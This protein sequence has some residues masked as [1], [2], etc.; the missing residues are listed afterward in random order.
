MKKYLITGGAGFIGSHLAEKLS[1]KANV[2][3]IDNLFQ[4]NKLKLNKNIKLVVGD[5][6]DKKLV[7]KH[8]KGCTSIFHLAAI[9]GVDVVAKNKLETMHVEFEGL[10]NIC[11]SAIKNNV[12]K[13][14]YA[15][16]SG[17][18]GKLN[19]GKKVK[20][21]S[22]IAPISGYAVAKRTCEI[23]LENFN[24]EAPHINCASLRLFN[25]YGSRQDSRM[26][27][28]RFIDKAKKNID[29][30]I[31]GDGN[32][33]RDFTYIDDCIKTFLLVEKKIKGYETFN[34]SKGKDIKIKNLAQIIK[35]LFK[36]NSKIIFIKVP[37]QL[38]EFQVKKRC[39]NSNKIF[40]YINFKPNISLLEGLKK[41]YF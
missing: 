23:Y 36:S 33:T 7:L 13:I 15:S 40:K 29:I 24:K 21:N 30:K 25:V 12:K 5:I 18:Y 17:V 37:K 35:K 10:K 4:G 22:I 6:R 31:Y 8:S 26:V 14:I 19:Y 11:E 28:P 3:V 27:I 9:I 41:I 32:Q 16:S 2:I 38:E 39:G 1:K 20:E 34:S